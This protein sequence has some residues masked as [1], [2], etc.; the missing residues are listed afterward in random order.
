MDI[1][2]VY[3]RPANF[4]AYVCANDTLCLKIRTKK[5]DVLSIKCLA[6]D[7]YDW[8][9][10]DWKTSE[11]AMRKSGTDE[12]YDYWVLEVSPEYRRLRYGFVLS[13]D[14]EKHFYGDKGF[15]TEIPSDIAHY[16]CFPYMNKIDAFTA[17][18]WVKDTVWYQIFPE[19][20]ANGDSSIN[21]EGTLEWASEG[22]SPTN[23][24]GGDIEGMIQHLDYL[25]TLGVNGLYLTPIFTAASNHKYDTIDYFELDPQ[26][27][28]KET[29][30][31][32][33]D[34]CHIRG[35]RVMLDAVFNHSGYYFPPFQ[36]VLEKGE[37]S[38][39][40]DWFHIRDFPIVTEPRPNYETFAFT[41]FMPKL[42]TENAEVKNYL[43]E[44]ARYWIRDFDIDGWRLDVANEVDHAFWREFRQEVKA[45]KPEL[46]ILGEIWHDSLPWLQGDQF[47][48]VMNYPFTTN[49]LNLFANKT[50]C[51]STFM[52]KMTQVWHMYPVSI[53]PFLFNLLD[54]HDTPRI[55]TECGEN[56]DLA[57]QIFAILLTYPGS[58]CIY[59]GDEIGM[60]GG[61]DPGCRKCM[62]WDTSKQNQ[63]LFHHI[64]SLIALRK[65]QP[66]LANNGEFS[67]LPLND[68]TPFIAYERRTEEEAVLVVLNTDS[69]SHVFS[70]TDPYLSKTLTSLWDDGEKILNNTIELQPYGMS[71]LHVKL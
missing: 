10:S 64:Q 58:P 55:L 48:S 60:V 46:Y 15:S 59:Y 57:K 27:G 22:P 36:D 26:F 12:W 50:I 21:P 43:L 29:F 69:T 11:Y 45:I 63:D 62:E 44:A 52:K 2:A 65:Q 51:P 32:F 34:E 37:A 66:L 53:N 1:E 41:P 13:N 39:Y 20:F 67:F 71:I 7:P 42:N 17:P 40:K 70:L 9:L 6:G 3:H 33:I 68:D 61:Q 24:F 19:R 47:D 25:N 31:R 18:H 23:F 56:I 16:F 4:D 5:E 30:K 38:R 8:V 35:I 49:I 14:E 28:S 54:S